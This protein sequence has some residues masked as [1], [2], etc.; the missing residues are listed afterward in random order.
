M[1]TATIK[2]MKSNFRTPWG[3]DKHITEF[4]TRL[5]RNQAE[6][7]DIGIVIGEVE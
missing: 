6:L 3:E 7:N 2:K 5:E 4:R 1:E